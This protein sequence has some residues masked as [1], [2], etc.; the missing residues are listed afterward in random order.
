MKIPATPRATVDQTASSATVLGVV[1]ENISSGERLDD[2][3]QRDTLLGHG[4]GGV[5]GN[6]KAACG[7]P[8]T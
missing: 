3:V 7:N 5:L 2:L 6:A 4:L 1:L 8:D